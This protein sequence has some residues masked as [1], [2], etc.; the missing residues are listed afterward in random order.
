MVEWP[1]KTDIIRV[2]DDLRCLTNEGLIPIIA[3]AERLQ[4]FQRDI[5]QLVKL[6][7][8]LEIRIQ[9][10]AHT[11]IEPANFRVRRFVQRLFKE[12]AVDYIGSDAHDTAYRRVRMHEAYDLISKRYGTSIAKKTMFENQYEIVGYNYQNSGGK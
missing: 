2:S 1:G 5:A 4:C 9:I 11:V 8:T 6:R 10:N 12:E 3:H 7:N